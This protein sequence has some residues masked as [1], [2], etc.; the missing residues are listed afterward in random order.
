M[1]LNRLRHVKGAHDSSVWSLSWCPDDSFLT[2]SLDERVVLWTHDPDGNVTK[3]HTFL[4][5]GLGT[6][7]LSVHQDGQYAAS[8]CLDGCVR[9]WDI[10]DHSKKL[11]TFQTAASENWGIH[12]APVREKV[13]LAVAGG[14]TSS[15][16]VYTL[17]EETKKHMTLRLPRFRDGQQQRSQKP[18]FVLTSKFSPDG[19]S[20][21]G[22]CNNGIVALFDIETGKELFTFTENTTPVRTTDFTPSKKC[23]MS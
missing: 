21:V 6:V 8:S 16:S 20:I 22:T 7:F 15:I 9:V 18:C 2:G 19:K 13:I 3:K 10:Q 14:S 1:H 11:H 4:S 23:E 17:G 12:F 5:H